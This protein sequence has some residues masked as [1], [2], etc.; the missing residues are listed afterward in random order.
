MKLRD[1]QRDI[2]QQVESAAGHPLVQ[3]DTGAGKT[4]IIAAL[5]ARSRRCIVVAHR[6]E[7][8][9]QASEK[10]AAQGVEHDTISTEHTR[11]RAILRQRRAGH[12][13]ALRRGNETH[14]VASLLSLAA[15]LDRNPA[16][17]DTGAE[18]MIIIDEAHHVQPDNLWGSLKT[19]F[20]QARIV[21]FT[22]TPARYDGGPLHVDFG[23]LFTT[24]IQAES[25]R[26]HSD[27]TLTER[28]YLCGFDAIYPAHELPS[29][30]DQ[31]ELAI[32]GD[33]VATYKKRALGRRAL[34]ICASIAN[35]REQVKQFRAAGIA[36]AYIAHDLGAVT[37]AETLDRFS[38]GAIDV[39]CSVDMISEGFDLPEAEVLILLSRT[40]SFVR[41]RQWVG[42]VRRPKPDGRKSLI[43][44]HVG[45][46]L[47]HGMPDDPV[48]WDIRNPPARATRLQQA[49]CEACGVFYSLQRHHCPDCGAANP[50]FTRGGPIG[51]FHLRIR[52]YLD[53]Q[54]L[55]RVEQARR[56][57][58][59][60]E[61]LRTRLFIPPQLAALASGSVVSKGL[62]RL[63]SWSADAL[64]S[65]GKP[66]AEVNGFLCDREI[67]KA[68]WW[69]KRFQIADINQPSGLEKIEKA[70]HAWQKS[71]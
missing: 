59:I 32:A 46:L 66:L 41:F 12:G 51:G 3:L 71:Q 26:E 5:A 47:E 30:R 56:R 27:R 17:L 38:A 24:L 6:N 65:S 35:A 15:L 70:F 63:V 4:P 16:A 67:V 53:A 54:M 40:G 45:M 43:I 37:V 68:E 19:R 18:W 52:Q 1:Y 23:G 64:V 21:G 10:L 9:V 62:F 14:L 50:L 8:A 33:P 44:D 25:L 55:E 2:L 34:A 39:L 42:R 13:S 36:A 29:L 49:P 58:Q 69:F 22:G 31:G 28:G 61:Q 7:L 20:P 60:D 57:E 48:I 11:R